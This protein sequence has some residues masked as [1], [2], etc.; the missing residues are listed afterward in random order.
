MDPRRRAAKTDRNPL[1]GVLERVL[2]RRVLSVTEVAEA[3]R[4][5]G[6]KP[7]ARSL[8]GAVSI[9]LAT[10]PHLFRRVQRGWYTSAARPARRNSRRIPTGL[11]SRGPRPGSSVSALLKVLD[12]RTMTISE[13][14]GALR[15]RRYKTGATAKSLY[16]TAAEALAQSGRFRRVGRGIY[17]MR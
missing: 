4:R 16:H 17:T 7:T 14:V 8:Y 11:G 12:G 6:Y 10:K 15:K 3:V 9:T 2:D 1:I 13:A 5:T